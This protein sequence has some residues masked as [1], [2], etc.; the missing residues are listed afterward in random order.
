M[1]STPSTPVLSPLGIIDASSASASK[2]RATVFARAAIRPAFWITPLALIAA[3]IKIA[4]ALN[5]FGTNDVAA[6]YAFARSLSD[7]GLE[8]T[9]KTALFGSPDLFSITRL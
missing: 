6:F 4:I 8:W 7:H 5:T 9:Y 2:I 3:A 1:E